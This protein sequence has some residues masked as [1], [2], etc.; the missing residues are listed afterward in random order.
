MGV[1]HPPDKHFFQVPRES[2]IFRKNNRFYAAHRM[3]SSMNW[4]MIPSKSLNPYS[5]DLSGF[6]D[7]ID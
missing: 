2:L 3:V 4:L 7:L 6:D 1:C 5:W